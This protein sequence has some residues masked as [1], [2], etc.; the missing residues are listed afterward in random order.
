MDELERTHIR[1]TYLLQGGD[2][3]HHIVRNAL[4]LGVHSR[5]FNGQK[6]FLLSTEGFIADALGAS[7]PLSVEAE[8]AEIETAVNGVNE[9]NA[10]PNER[11]IDEELDL[12]TDCLETEETV[13]VRPVATDEV[14][15]HL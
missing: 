4:N 11:E 7:I 8:T 14:L 2:F 12:L 15:K 6:L 1:M 5:P 10:L 13:H 3:P 9:R